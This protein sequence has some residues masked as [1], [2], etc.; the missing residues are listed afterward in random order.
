MADK[1]DYYEV[2]GVSKGAS[3]DELKKAFR[4]LAKQYHPDLHPDDKECEAKFKEINE[5]YEV[6]SDSGKRAKYDQFGFAGVDP[7]YGAG[8][9]GAYSGGFGGF[10]G[11]FDFSDIFDGFFGGGFSGGRQASTNAPRK[12]RDISVNVTISFMEACKGKKTDVRINR[13]EK[14]EECDGSGA[15]KGTTAQTCSECHGTGQVTVTQRMG[16]FGSIQSKRACTKCGGKGKIITSPCSK[17]SGSG[18]VRKPVTTEV[19]I[20]AGIDDG[21]TFRVPGYG[22]AGTNGGPSGDLNIVVSVRPDPIFERDGYD[23]W[24][25]IPITFTQ[26]TLGDEITVPTIDGKVKYTIPAGT[27]SDTKFRLK[28]KGVRRPYKTDRGDQ[29]VRVIV[30]IPKNLSKKQAELLKAFEAS[31]ENGDNYQKRK[32]F[33]EK[34]KDN[35]ES[36]K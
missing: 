5:A 2:L 6:L 31:M 15:Q 30:E 35:F 14:C 22:D 34:L 4:K 23:I 17:C 16:G 32:G 18:R 19:E 3:E 33:F 29:Y 25:D 20:P 26:A 21:Q 28:N 1:R 27:Q 11:G 13:Q 36:K 12:G 7:S 10:G 8:Q 24:T 9:G